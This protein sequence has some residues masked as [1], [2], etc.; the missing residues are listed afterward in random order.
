ML[1]KKTELSASSVE[2]S[3]PISRSSPAPSAGQ[4]FSFRPGL[5]KICLVFEADQRQEEV[6]ESMAEKAQFLSFSPL[7]AALSYSRVWEINSVLDFDTSNILV[8]LFFGVS[9]SK[10]HISLSFSLA[11]NVFPPTQIRILIK[12]SIFQLINFSFYPLIFK[13]KIFISL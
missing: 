7:Q 9:L 8:F 11:Y 1:K 6:I 2:C 3:E 4:I 5:Q 13:F 10:C 12:A